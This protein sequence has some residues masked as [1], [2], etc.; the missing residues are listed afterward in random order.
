MKICPVC[1]TESD[2]NAKFCQE[3][4]TP[5]SDAAA[6]TGSDY[7]EASAADTAEPVVLISETAEDSQP[8]DASVQAV[9]TEDAPKAENTLENSSASKSADSESSNERWYYVESGKSKGPYSRSEFLDLIVAGTVK[10]ET[11][12]WTKGMDEWTYLK[13][14]DLYTTGDD[15]TESAAIEESAG[16]PVYDSELT[17]DQPDSVDSQPDYEETSGESQEWYYVV[18]SRTVGPF[19]ESV[20]IRNIQQ[21][22]LVAS[23]YVWKEGYPDWKHLS[24]TPLA[25][26]LPTDHV[27]NTTTFNEPNRGPVYTGPTMTAPVPSRSILLYLL[28]SILTCGIFEIVWLYLIASDINK[29][30]AQKG[31]RP[32]TDPILVVIFSLLTCQIFSVYY[33]WKAGNT[34]YELSDRRLSDNSLVLAILGVFLQPAALAILQ[35]QINS[36]VQSGEYR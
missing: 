36:L 6:R 31:Q 20:M 23:T 2:D 10:P 27:N 12:V 30:C 25:A 3:C 17:Y 11:Y 5:L 8:A 9:N 16:I 35:D 33:F 15:S 22:V 26:Y 1:H 29:L 32:L 4:G 13:N 34:I 24:D 18:N 14:T 7:T 19:S 28:L 21:G